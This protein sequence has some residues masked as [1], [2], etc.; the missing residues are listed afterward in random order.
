MH[1]P[2]IEDVAQG[3]I[4]VCKDG[5]YARQVVIQKLKSGRIRLVCENTGGESIAFSE[6]LLAQVQQ[7]I[8]GDQIDWDEVDV[9]EG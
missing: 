9:E 3:W 2:I 5:S 4:Y 7:M 1:K 8:D 6:K